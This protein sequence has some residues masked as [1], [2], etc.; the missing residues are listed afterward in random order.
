MYSYDA[1]VKIRT[2]SEY[3][4][5]KKGNWSFLD[6]K[7]WNLDSEYLKPLKDFLKS[8]FEA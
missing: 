8:L 4:D 2:K 7:Y 1:A 3:E 5:F 6:K